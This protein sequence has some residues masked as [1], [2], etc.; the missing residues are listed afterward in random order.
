MIMARVDF[1]IQG[2][3]ITWPEIEPRIAKV[4][5]CPPC[6]RVMEQTLDLATVI[7]PIVLKKSPFPQLCDD[8]D[9]GPFST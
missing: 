4:T 5:S 2:Q 3:P 6:Q 9:V 1:L 7:T 8:R